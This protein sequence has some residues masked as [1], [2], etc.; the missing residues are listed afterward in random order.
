MSNQRGGGRGAGAGRT[1]FVYKPRTNEAANARRERYQSGNR[2]SF[3]QPNVE[4]WKPA[5]GD[6]WIR[7]LPPSWDNADHYALELYVHYEVGPDN[8]TYLCPNKMQG[9]Q[10]GLCDEYHAAKSA[11]EEDYARA[12]EVSMRLGAWIIDRDNEK[13]GVQ[14]WLF[15]TAQD[16]EIMQQAYDRRTGETI[17]IDHPQDGYD[18]EFTRRGKGLQTKYSGFKL[19]RQPSEV[20]ASALQFISDNPLP[21]IL[22]YYDNEYI[23]AAFAGTGAAAN[24]PADEPKQERQ[25]QQERQQTSTQRQPVQ[26]RTQTNPPAER[27]QTQQ[28]QPVQTRGETQQQT[29]AATGNSARRA[30]LQQQKQQ[31]EKQLPDFYAMS[32]EEQIDWAEQ[33]NFDIPEDIGDEEIAKWLEQKCLE[34]EI[35]F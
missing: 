16:R 5:D 19:S 13:S 23:M 26:A 4:M 15:S 25:P 11:K 20:S 17:M 1:N 21:S 3:V 34:D 30:R 9:L 31:P 14:L 28:R 35:P 22:K 2:D 27:T 6:N 12:L 33:H 24:K 29:T 7:I 10:C 18:I 8:N 32:I